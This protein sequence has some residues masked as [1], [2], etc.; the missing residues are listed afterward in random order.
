MYQITLRNKMQFNLETIFY[1][2]S[3]PLMKYNF[4]GETP[5]PLSLNFAVLAQNMLLVFLNRS[6]TPHEHFMKIILKNFKK[7]FTHINVI[8][9]HTICAS[10]RFA[11]FNKQHSYHNML[12]Y[13]FCIFFLSCVHIPIIKVYLHLPAM[14]YRQNWLYKNGYS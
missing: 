1:K 10:F 12:H 8:Y 11:V 6:R 14:E 3:L 2:R 13:S 4:N 5:L 9:V 7:L